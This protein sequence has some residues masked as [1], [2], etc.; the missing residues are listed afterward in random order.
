MHRREFVRLAGTGLSAA[1]LAEA[2]V[3]AQIGASPAARPAAAPRRAPQARMKLGTQQGDAEEMLRAFAAFGCNNIC[4]SLPSPKM[5]DA[6]SVGAL[7]KRRERVAAHG[8]SLD[9]PPLPG[10]F[11][12]DS[13]AELPAIFSRHEPRARPQHRRHLLMIRNCARAGSCR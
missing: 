10:E 13:R 5:D 4:G 8:I 9:T 2:V 7:S 6:W 3:A 11:E 1:A 12:R